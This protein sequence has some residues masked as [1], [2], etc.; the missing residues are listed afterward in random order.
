MSLWDTYQSRLDAHGGDRR[1]ALLRRVSR[2]LRTKMPASLSFHS[3]LLN[4]EPRSLSII[5][6]D[7]LDQ[8]TLCTLPGEDLPHGGMVEWMGNHWLIT[9]RDANNEVYTKGIMRQCNY[10]LRWIAEDGNIIERWCIVEDGTKYLTGEYSDKD[11]ILSV[12]D[13]RISVTLA[14]DPYT[15]QLNRDKR[16][17]IDHYGYHNVLAYSLTKPF[18]LGG[19]Y[20]N[21]GVVRFIMQETNTVDTDNFELHIANYYDCFPRKEAAKP[22]TRKEEGKKVWL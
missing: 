22:D 8:K 19:S 2:S 6:S 18:K 16:F 1:G 9:E 4:G 12:G 14:V 13:S 15:L 20:N 5:N 7:N 11:F 21:S 10:L 3:V 17:L